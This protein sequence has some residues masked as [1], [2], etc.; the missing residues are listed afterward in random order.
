MD[1]IKGRTFL[2]Q[3]RIRL[4]LLVERQT[5]TRLL[6]RGFALFKQM[7]IEPATFFKRGVEPLQLFLR[8]IDPILEGFTHGSILCLNWSFVKGV[9]SP[10]SPPI[11]GGPIHPLVKTEGLSWPRSV[12]KHNGKQIVCALRKGMV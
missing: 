2:L 7:V 11:K 5:L 6:I 12:K 1:R 4:V 8:R 9:G 10:P 3:Y